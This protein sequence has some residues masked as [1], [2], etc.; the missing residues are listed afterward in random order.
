MAT[1]DKKDTSIKQLD[2][3]TARL[4]RLTLQDYFGCKLIRKKYQNKRNTDDGRAGEQTNKEKTPTQMKIN[5]VNM[6]LNTF[7]IQLWRQ[8]TPKRFGEI[9]EILKNNEVQL[10]K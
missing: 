4:S 3:Q 8:S 6:H 1:C 9:N 7:L 5:Q 10:I 2:D